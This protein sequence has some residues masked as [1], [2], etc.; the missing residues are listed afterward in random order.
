MG[1][2]DGAYVLLLPAEPDPGDA[3]RRVL[4]KAGQ[5]VGAPGMVTMVAGPVA[6]LA[7]TIREIARLGALCG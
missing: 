4:A 2:Y 1:P 6:K 7:L 5:A 3:L